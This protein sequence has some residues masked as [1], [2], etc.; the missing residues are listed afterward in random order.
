M[1]MQF[2]KLL[3]HDAVQLCYM[4]HHVTV[5]NVQ[6]TRKLCALTASAPAHP[7][8]PQPRLSP[9]LTGLMGAATLNPSCAS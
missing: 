3:G 6:E 9:P 7:R 4:H 5:V 2:T 1:H 8:Q